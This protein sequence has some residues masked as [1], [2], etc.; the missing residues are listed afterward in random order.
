M[1]RTVYLQYQCGNRASL[2]TQSFEELGFTHA[3]AAVM[4]LEDWQKTGHPFVTADFNALFT[5]H[6]TEFH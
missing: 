6:A 1:G 5:P 4:S 3:A 2:A